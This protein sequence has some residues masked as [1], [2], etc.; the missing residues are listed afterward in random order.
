[1][2]TL[3]KL[4]VLFLFFSCSCPK[5]TYYITDFGAKG[6]GKTNNTDAINKAIKTCSKNGGGTVMVPPG[7]YVSG[8]IQ[9]L[10]NLNLEL[11]SGAVI[12]GS[13]D[14]A[15]YRVEGRYDT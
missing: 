1:M 13:L 8:S 7:E 4:F 10:S 11:M 14:T 5:G 15:D 12:K 6:D 9:L 3:F 2:K